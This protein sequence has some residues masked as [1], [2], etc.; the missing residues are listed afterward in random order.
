MMVLLAV[1]GLGI[2]CVV[3]WCEIE[4]GIGPGLAGVVVVVLEL[5]LL[6]LWMS[7]QGLAWWDWR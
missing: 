3:C 5:C 1:V 7:N 4:I 2:E 6:S